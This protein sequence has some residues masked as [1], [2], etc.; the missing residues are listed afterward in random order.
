MRKTLAAFCLLMLAGCVGYDTP[1]ELKN[2]TFHEQFQL[3][4]N[5]QQIFQCYTE[6]ERARQRPIDAQIYSET[7]LAVMDYLL[8]L[9]TGFSVPG[10]DGWY[11][12]AELR[13]IDATHTKVDVWHG[14]EDQLAD[15]SAVIKSCAAS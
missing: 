4:G 8:K 15:I 2:K 7:G 5:Y 9:V 3:N 10:S 1:T 12:R 6:K 11:A 14:R 13:K